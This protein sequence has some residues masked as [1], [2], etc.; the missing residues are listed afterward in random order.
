MRLLLIVGTQ[1]RHQYFLSVLAKNFEIA[2][3]IEYE[4]TLVQ[5]AKLNEES[6]FIDDLE[7]ERQHLKR[8]QEKEV[9][10][11]SEGVNAFDRN[12]HRIIS[13]KNRQELNS[14][15]TKLWIESINANVML[16]YGSGI[17]EKSILDVLP[18]WKINLHGG[19]SP[20]Y[21]GSATLFWPF[22]MQQ[23]ELAGMTFHLLS[24]HI[25]GGDII[26]HCRPYMYE[27][28][29]I[30]DIGCRAVVEAS[31]VAVLLLRKLSVNGTLKSYP[32]K[33]GK[34]F[35]EKDY[36][37]S[38]VKVIN[39]LFEHGLIKEYLRQ[40]QSRDS[41]YEFINQLGE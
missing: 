27:N 5:P 12:K 1:L 34:L 41:Q 20:Y 23:P 7:A 26:Q 31:E 24:A 32:Q 18:E 10:Y 25:D 8:L 39:V 13:V 40:K 6:F 38:C 9:E 30:S 19:L 35:L 15:Q 37:P 29:T 11:F 3:V 17:L 21:K 14:S 22:Y 28:D 16:D 36:K 4:R 2:G 33:G